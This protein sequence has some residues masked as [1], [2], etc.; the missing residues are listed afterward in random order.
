MLS[1]LLKIGSWIKAA[2]KWLWS[3]PVVL[4]SIIGAIVGG[5][6]IY[7][8]N[9]NKIDSLKDAVEVH[10]AKSKIAKNTAKVESLEKRADEKAKKAKE[11]K[12]E[13]AASK[14]RVVE[15]NEQKSVE[16]MNDDEVA[17]LFSDSGF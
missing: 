11:L 13:I 12:N 10:K 7:R 15:I 2:V 8:S 14:R 17:K 5:L 3:R 6:F 16:G 9:K 4:A 1:I